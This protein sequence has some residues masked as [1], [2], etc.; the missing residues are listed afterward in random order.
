M[1]LMDCGAA[2]MSV[3]YEHEYVRFVTPKE[4]RSRI[5]WSVS[6]IAFLVSVLLPFYQFIIKAIF[7]LTFSFLWYAFAAKDILV[8]NGKIRLIIDEEYAV[9]IRVLLRAPGLTQMTSYSRWNIKIPIS[10]IADVS[11]KRTIDLKTTESLLDD[12]GVFKHFFIN[13][14]LCFQ[15]YRYIFLLHTSPLMDGRFVCIKL[16]NSKMVLIEFDDAE[17]FADILRKSKILQEDKGIDV[18]NIKRIIQGGNNA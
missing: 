17:N 4:R 12:K 15:I 11:V 2:V 1:R 5:F 13:R 6:V 14:K 7:V 16:K 18:N 9:I 10:E 8:R 3:I